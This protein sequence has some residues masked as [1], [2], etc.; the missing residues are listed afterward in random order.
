[1]VDNRANSGEAAGVPRGEHPLDAE[2]GCLPAF[3]AF[4]RAD[5][6]SFFGRERLVADLTEGPGLR[7]ESEPAVLPVV[8][9]PPLRGRASRPTVQLSCRS[10]LPGVRRGDLPGPWR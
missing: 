6:G 8:L 1:M 10:D 4:Q 7:P 5:A 3:A 9:L 2:E